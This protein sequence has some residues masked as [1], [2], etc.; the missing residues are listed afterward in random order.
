MFLALIFSTKIREND[1]S[2]LNNDKKVGDGY[3]SDWWTKTVGV[4]GGT[5]VTGGDAELSI[6]VCR[7]VGESD[8]S[9]PIVQVF[10]SSHPSVDLHLQ[11][12]WSFGQCSDFSQ[13]DIGMGCTSVDVG[14]GI[15]ILIHSH[16]TFQP[17]W[18]E[19]RIRIEISIGTLK[20]N[21]AAIHLLGHR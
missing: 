9:V 8:G 7:L 11:A 21:N 1:R 20:F 13:P 16:G 6:F 18:I 3:I 17:R 2:L 14:N 5:T 19:Q 12:C 10:H 15:T 4:S